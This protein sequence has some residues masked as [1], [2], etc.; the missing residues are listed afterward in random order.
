MYKFPQTNKSI[1]NGREFDPYDIVANVFG[2]LP[3]LAIC[4]WYHRRMLERKR[5]SKSYSLVPGDADDEHDL[6]LGEGIGAANRDGQETGVTGQ[7]LE[8]EVDNWDENAE[9]WDDDEPPVKSGA[10]EGEG[11]K[12]P[13]ASVEDAVVEPVKKRTD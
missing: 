10:E 8:Q 5:L 7:T 11:H 6:E 1:Q 9:D 2:T 3:A 4:T 12:T 13:G